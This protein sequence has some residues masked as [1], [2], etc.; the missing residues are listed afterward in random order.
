[1]F[2]VIFYTYKVKNIELQAQLTYMLFFIIKIG[3][4]AAMFLEL[5]DT[6]DL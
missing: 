5:K 4:L 6:S 1:M 3:F 2:L